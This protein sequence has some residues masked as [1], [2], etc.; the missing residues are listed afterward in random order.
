MSKLDLS[1]EDYKKYLKEY[2][3]RGASYRKRSRSK[4]IGSKE[5]EQAYREYLDCQAMV[6][7][8]N[9]K[10]K[11]GEWLY[12]DLPNGHMINHYRIIAS[13]DPDR[14]GKLVDNSG[15]EWDVPR[16]RN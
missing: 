10:M 13:G 7:N 9:W 3:E 16:K 14:I 8:L 4:N 2:Q 15:K 5:S 12:D 11:H 1:K 6:R